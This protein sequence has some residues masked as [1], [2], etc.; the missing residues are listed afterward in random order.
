MF[1]TYKTPAT[2][3]SSQT[4]FHGLTQASSA[5][6]WTVGLGASTGKHLLAQVPGC[7]QVSM[8]PWGPQ[9]RLHPGHLALCPLRVLADGQAQFGPVV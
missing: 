5:E 6:C 1:F 9:V 4:V 8:V 2:L 7:A 3:V